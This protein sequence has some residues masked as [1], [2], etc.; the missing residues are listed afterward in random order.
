L[1]LINSPSHITNLSGDEKIYK[2]EFL[3]H[4]DLDKYVY[5]I[6]KNLSW[7][8]L[9]LGSLVNLSLVLD[10]MLVSSEVYLIW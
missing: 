4:H 7:S 3:A 8:I 9:F 5:W 10:K 6:V 1:F 2:D